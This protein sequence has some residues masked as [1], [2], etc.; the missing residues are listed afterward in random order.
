MPSTNASHATNADDPRAAGE[1]RST[2]GPRLA[3]GADVVG[4][5]SSGPRLAVGADVVGQFSSSLLE[6]QVGLAA[7][8]EG[9]VLA[10]P[11]ARL[12]ELEAALCRAVRRRRHA[13]ERQG[14]RRGWPRRRYA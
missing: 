5:F 11:P 13:W 9:L 1:G 2:P 10:E 7:L 4:Q 14:K 8:R 6:H 12:A 3:V